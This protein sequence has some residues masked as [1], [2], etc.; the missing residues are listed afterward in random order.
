MNISEIAIKRPVFTV[1]VTLSLVVLGILGL[2]RLG[3]DLFPDISVPIVSITV[4]YPGASPAE[5]ESL[6]VKEVEDA[7][8][9]LNGIDHI[10]TTSREGA[11]VIVVLFKIGVNM[12]EAATQVRERITQV[13][14]RLPVDSKE[15]LIKRLD[16]S[17][18]PVVVYS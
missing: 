3:T 7:V 18:A 15:P 12:E 5:V 2:S 6:V 14:P 11:G 13:R 9:S 17:A 16:A 4:P 1:M 8:V 10:Q